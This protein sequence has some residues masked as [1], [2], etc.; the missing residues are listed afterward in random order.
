MRKHLDVQFFDYLVSTAIW[1]IVETVTKLGSE[2]VRS[3]V[4][5]SQKFHLRGLRRPR[6]L[7]NAITK[8]RLGISRALVLNLIRPP[9]AKCLT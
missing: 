5:V 8:P 4:R 7:V 1:R 3:E 6:C 2:L 9:G